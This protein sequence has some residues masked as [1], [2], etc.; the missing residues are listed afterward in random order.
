MKKLLSGIFAFCIF[1]FVACTKESNTESLND[2]QQIQTENL[3]N[4]K[5]SFNF[6]TGSSNIVELINANQEFSLPL[7]QNT[8]D[9]M[10]NAAGYDETMHVEDVNKIIDEVMVGR[11]LGIEKY[12]DNYTDLKEDSKGLIKQM[13]TEG[14]IKDL[15]RNEVFRSLPEKDQTIIRTGNQLVT[16][17]DIKSNGRTMSPA[18]FG[19]CGVIAGGGIG[20]AIG[21]PV[22]GVI[23]GMIGGMVGLVV[24]VFSN[25]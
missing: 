9:E 7:D 20:W 21:G 1:T 24:G 23:G 4:N 25:K 6:K 3:V 5:A 8:L 14:A 22:G 19:M 10:L 16:D 15:E 2:N 17:Y 13:L 18:E 12:M 11:E